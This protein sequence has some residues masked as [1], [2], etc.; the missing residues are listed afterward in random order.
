MRGIFFKTKFPEANF[1]LVG[2]EKSFKEGNWSINEANLKYF[3]VEP[4]ERES[5]P[6]AASKRV[7]KRLSLDLK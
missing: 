6:G 4:D 1:V 3:P 7:I 2:I 5:P